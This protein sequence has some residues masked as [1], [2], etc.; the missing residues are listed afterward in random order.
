[1]C[2]NSANMQIFKSKFC[3][4]AIEKLPRRSRKKFTGSLNKVLNHHLPISDN[5]LQFSITGITN[6][7]DFNINLIGE[8]VLIGTVLEC[9]LV[10]CFG[11]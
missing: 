6:S 8:E 1:M 5:K 3:Q 2:M 4:W 11:K 10:S 9:S 7:H